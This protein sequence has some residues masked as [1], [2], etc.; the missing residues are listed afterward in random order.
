MPSHQFFQWKFSLN[1]RNSSPY[2]CIAATTSGLASFT[3]D[4]WPFKTTKRNEETSITS[5]AGVTCNIRPETGRLD[6]LSGKNESRGEGAGRQPSAQFLIPN[7][8]PRVA[9]LAGKGAADNTD[10]TVGT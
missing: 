4:L 6:L 9:I 1:L 5:A 10:D 8:P 3:V 2:V 7:A